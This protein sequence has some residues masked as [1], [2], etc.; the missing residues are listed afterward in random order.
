MKLSIHSI[1]SL[2]VLAV[3]ALPYTADAASLYIDPAQ[4]SLNRGDALT[5]AVRLDTD[6]SVGECVNAVDAVITYTANIDPV[7]VSIGN[8]IFSMWVEQPTINR[9]DRTITFAGG[10]PNG[11][12]GRVSGDPQL[13]NVMAELIFRS[14][15]FAIGGSD[16]PVARVAFADTSTAYLNDGQG[17][18]ASLTNYGAEIALNDRPG[19][20]ML[21]PWQ[22]RVDADTT[23]PEE[24][25]ITLEQDSTTFSGRHYI[26]FSTTDKQTGIDHYEVMEEPISQLGTFEWGRADAPWITARSPYELDDQSLNS[27]IRVKAVDKAGNQ[28]IA[29]LI[30]DE[31]M[32]TLSQDKL[33]F[34]VFVSFLGLVLL[35]VLLS[36]FA[37]Y[38]KMKKR[39]AASPHQ[40]DGQTE[41]DQRTDTHDA[42]D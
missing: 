6:E 27:I 28:Y 9:E 36:L 21:N 20:E 38:R 5:F 37:W 11:Y 30:P 26:V 39:A 17:S 19:A 23:R 2:C 22:E 31:S 10:I 1:F 32:R 42:Y 25:S 8:S 35:L 12:C 33:I 18:K 40:P 13:T 4:S 34:Y 24:F 41:D 7:D 15:G 16:E 14:P 29:T 3:C